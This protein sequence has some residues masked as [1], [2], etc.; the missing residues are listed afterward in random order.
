MKKIYLVTLLC[1]M[2]PKQNSFAA[3]ND[4][5]PWKIKARAIV[6]KYLGNEWGLKLFGEKSKKY[7]LPE[8]PIVDEDAKST[9]VYKKKYI[10]SIKLNSEVELKLNIAYVSELYE[11]IKER[12]GVGSEVGNWINVMDQGG[13]REGVYRALVLD[14]D[15][16][17]MENYDRPISNA[18]AN[19]A[20]NFSNKYAG[21]DINKDTLVKVNFYSV[22]RLVTEK[23]LE[24]IDAF[25]KREDLF[26]W[27]AIMSVQMAKKYNYAFDNEVRKNIDYNYHINWANQVPRQHL[28]SEVIVK[29]HRV[30]NNLQKIE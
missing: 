13:S 2:I 12:K 20:H 26:K 25:E 18:G 24:I 30:F 15:Y 7:E 27:Y 10:E 9:E 14:R 17:G 6:E 23:A 8:I 19:F 4:L 22:K 3:T 21:M 11:V 29:L 16:Q 1:L 28:K 5:P